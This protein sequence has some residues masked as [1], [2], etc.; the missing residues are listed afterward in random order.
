MPDI[1]LTIHPRFAW[2][3]EPPAIPAGVYTGYYDSGSRQWIFVFDESA[4]QG[5]LFASGTGWIRR[6][7]LE[8]GRLPQDVVLNGSEAGWAL[9]CWRAAQSRKAG[10]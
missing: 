10:C 8:N 5:W 6:Y 3:G 1:L 4:G 9:A 7:T 2:P